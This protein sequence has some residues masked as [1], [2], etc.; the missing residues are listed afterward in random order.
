[1]QRLRSLLPTAS[2]LIPTVL[3]LAA[4][5]NLCALAKQVADSAVL[6]AAD[7]HRAM[8]V[9]SNLVT[10][11]L[12]IRGGVNLVEAFLE[13]R[14]KSIETGRHY[15]YTWR[16]A[17]TGVAAIAGGAGLVYAQKLSGSTGQE[18]PSLLWN[19]ASGVCMTTA[20]FFA[21]R[22]NEAIK[23]GRTPQVAGGGL[24]VQEGERERQPAY[25]SL[26]NGSHA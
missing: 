20:G 6:T 25:A 24:Q 7:G 14:D 5:G 3:L 17:A 16:D 11:A 19:V 4:V 22:E 12:W 26:S 1:M 13:R 23:E 9:S 15:Q 8:N 18:I 2:E 21:K 10:A